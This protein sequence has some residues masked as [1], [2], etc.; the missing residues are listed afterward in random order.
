MAT[1]GIKRRCHVGFFGKTFCTILKAQH[2]V[3]VLHKLG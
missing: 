2:P 1:S 3:K